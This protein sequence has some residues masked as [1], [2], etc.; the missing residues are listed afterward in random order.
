LAIALPD[1]ATQRL[2]VAQERI[3]ARASGFYRWVGVE[4]MHLTLYFLGDMEDL[5]PVMNGLNQIKTDS[6]ELSIAGLVLLPERNVPRIIAAG[7]GGDTQSLTR[8]QQRISDT[9]FP[10]A[11]FKETRRYYPHITLGRLKRGMPGNAK[12]L[13]KTLAE[14]TIEQSE[15]FKVEEFLLM[16]S[17]QGEHGPHY[18][19]LHRFPLA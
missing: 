10:F 12:V 7:V 1:D 13:K 2:V 11:E 9:V 18:E 5:A 4:Q 6:F 15:P 17:Q 14:A 16:A 19:T 8:L 3:E